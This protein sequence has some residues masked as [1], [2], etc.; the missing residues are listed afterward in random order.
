MPGRHEGV[1][2]CYGVRLRGRAVVE[3]VVCFSPG[4]LPVVLFVVF[5][6]SC[7]IQGGAPG[8]HE[9]VAATLRGRGEQ[10]SSM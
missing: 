4:A 2:C 1:C 5:V 8:R 3:M 10:L 9:R 6:S 7:N